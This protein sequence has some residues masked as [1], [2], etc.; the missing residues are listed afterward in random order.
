MDMIYAITKVAGLILF[1]CVVFVCNTY[2]RYVDIDV[3][4]MDPEI[5]RKGLAVSSSK[6]LYTESVSELKE[7]ENK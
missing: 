2:S 4:Y 1:A 3:D 6:P 7:P 5:I